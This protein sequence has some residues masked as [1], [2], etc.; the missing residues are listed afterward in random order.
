MTKKETLGECLQ[1]LREKAGLSQ[2][3]LASKAGVSVPSLRNWEQD[4]RQLKLGAA[5]L[6]AKALGVSL[7]VLGACAAANEG[8]DTQRRRR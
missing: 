4:H 1:R 5:Y 2:S 3:E 8:K 7:D 6:V